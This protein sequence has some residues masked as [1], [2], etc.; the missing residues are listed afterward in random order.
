MAKKSKIT[1]QSL[2]K[3]KGKLTDSTKND[4]DNKD[5]IIARLNHAL[6]AL[7]ISKKICWQVTY[8]VILFIQE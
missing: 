8:Y 7:N 4:K 5:I 1:I 6:E 2:I 3:D